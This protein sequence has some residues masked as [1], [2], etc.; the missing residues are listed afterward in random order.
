MWAINWA[1]ARSEIAVLPGLFDL[2]HDYFHIFVGRVIG[3][4]FT[5]CV[6]L[7]DLDLVA[8]RSWMSPALR[9]DVHQH[10]QDLFTGKV[11]ILLW[12]CASYGM[13]GSLAFLLLV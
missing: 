2:Y 12:G 3:F 11:F 10:E 9:L 1:T 8:T 5:S 6:T 4:T 7:E 13:Y